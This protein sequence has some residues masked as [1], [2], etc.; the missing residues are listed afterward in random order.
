MIVWDG[1]LVDMYTDEEVFSRFR[2][3]RCKLVVL[4]VLVAN[5]VLDV[6]VANCC[7]LV[8][9][10]QDGGS[11]ER[12]VLSLALSKPSCGYREDTA[13]LQASKDFQGTRASNH[14]VPK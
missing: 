4:D 12:N 3:P 2:C 5:I 1:K 9:F 10:R 14:G 13:W 7:K 8:D 6:L 11:G